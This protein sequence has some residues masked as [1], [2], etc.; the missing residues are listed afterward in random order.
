MRILPGGEL[1]AFTITPSGGAKFQIYNSD[2][3]MDAD[4]D[5]AI[6][7]APLATDFANQKILA[8]SQ[9]MDLVR[10]GNTVFAF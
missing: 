8:P 1:A 2:G 4:Q 10:S 5:V 9:N 7:P 6:T 3:T